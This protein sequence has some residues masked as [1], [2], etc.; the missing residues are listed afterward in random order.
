[1]TA[2][3]SNC[4][5]SLQQIWRSI[6]LESNGV[7]QQPFL[8]YHSGALSGAQGIHHVLDKERLIELDVV[9]E[10]RQQ[11]LNS[12]SIPLNAYFGQG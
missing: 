4:S 10:L 9:F 7:K 6:F 2:R 8:E 5:T 3:I 11:A 1:M 12:E